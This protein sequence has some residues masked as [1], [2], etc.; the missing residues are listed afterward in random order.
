MQF[1]ILFFHNTKYLF[2]KK[3]KSVK[4]RLKKYCF[5]FPEAEIEMYN[6][7]PNDSHRQSGSIVL[8]ILPAQVIRLPGWK[9][10]LFCFNEEKKTKGV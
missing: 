4:V 7:R 3:K 6:F 9:S 5:F 1:Y 10:T 8:D 2:K